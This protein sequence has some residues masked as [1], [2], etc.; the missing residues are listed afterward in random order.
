MT[1]VTSLEG[2]IRA[3]YADVTQHGVQQ[4]REIAIVAHGTPIG[5]NFP[6]LD[7]TADRQMMQ[8]TPLALS[9]LQSQFRSGELATFA[10]Q[11]AV[12]LQHLAPGAWVTI[13]VC[14][15]GQ[16]DEGM[17]ALYSFFGGAVDV[18]APVKYQLFA[19][20]SLEQGAQPPDPASA[21]GLDGDT[22]RFLALMAGRA[23]DARALEAACRASSP[24][25]L[26]TDPALGIAASDRA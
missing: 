20:V 6:G 11:R 14:R 25:A 19:S 17:Y 26:D 8:V 15:F 24:P 12:V 10:A 18:Y 1:D 16:S 13:Q 9:N 3:L 22:R 7:S 2:V 5:M 21:A 4:I 23:V